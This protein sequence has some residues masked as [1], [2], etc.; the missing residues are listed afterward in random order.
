[1]DKKN[2]LAVDNIP[3][4][5]ELDEL[6]W[7]VKQK[8]KTESRENVYIL[9]AIK[10]NP[11]Q[12]AGFLVTENRSPETL[13]ELVDN[14]PPVKRYYTDG[15]LGYI[16]VIFPGDHVRNVRNKDGT[17][18]V[19][20]VNADLRHYIPILARRSRCFARSKETLR[21]VVEVF[22]AAYNRFGSAK[23]HFAMHR[24]RGEFPLGLVDFL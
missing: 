17:T 15:Y 13:Q 24:I 21:A 4:Y 19:E 7:F 12:I 23:H 2:D 6:F 3:D 9:T 16:N 8:A 1:M 14:A 10:N 18:T 5:L 22:A 11:R 20:S